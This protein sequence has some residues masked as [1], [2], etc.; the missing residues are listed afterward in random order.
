MVRLNH[1]DGH[2]RPSKD[3][4]PLCYCDVVYKNGSTGRAWRSIGFPEP[5]PLY[6]L[7]EMLASP[8]A[9]VIVTEGEKKAVAA[10]RLFPG[11][12]G[13]APAHGA[14]SPHRTNWSLCRDRHF[15]IWPDHDEPG[16]QFADRVARLLYDAGAASIAIVDVPEDF[17][18]KWDLADPAPEGA[19]LGALLAAAKI[20]TPNI[21]Q[22]PGP[23]DLKGNARRADWLD[24]CQ[25]GRGDMPLNNVTNAALGLRRE[26]T[27]IGCVAYDSFADTV[28]LMRPLPR[29]HEAAQQ[30]DPD[31]FESRHWQ[32]SDT[33][34]VQEWL[35]IL[36]L[37]TLSRANTE[38]AINLVAHENEFDPVKEWIEAQQRDQQS[39]IETWAIDC[40][41]CDDTPYTRAVSRF[42][43]IAAV[44]RIYEPGCKFDYCPILQDEQQGTQKS[45]ALRTLFDP[46]FSDSIP[47]DLN[48]K[49]AK[50]HL[51]G[52]WGLEFAEL[53]SLNRSHIDAVKLFL[54]QQHD[55]YRPSYGRRDQRFPRRCV[56]AGT[57][58][59]TVF[60]TDSSGNRRSWPLRTRNIDIGKLR[61][62]RGALFAEALELYKSHERYWPDRDEEKTLFK[63]E[64]EERFDGDE[65]ESVVVAY[66][67][68]KDRVLVGQ[69]ARDACL[70]TTDKIGRAVQNRII[71]IL[72]RVAWRRGKPDEHGKWW[73]RSADQ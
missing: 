73:T 10:S 71:E 5:R 18:Q 25:V 33:D 65:W 59:R 54:S 14:K 12:A 11:Y 36:G 57:T 45:T 24:E 64:Q 8:D 21:V 68:D 42:Y 4:L 53:H 47:A 1:L 43:I 38:T 40:L 32:D 67:A 46:W 31:E 20:W 6:Q 13:I 62:I 50:Q 28:M 56:F 49:D 2:G 3:Y 26:Q 60:L 61:S 16:R 41:G 19:D 72:E 22:F 30:E 70:V 7:P 55:D 23:A 58:N 17:P 44:A 27:L 66:L 9:P 52:K 35:Q 15:I 37:N 34:Q 39:H 48:A 69:I 29:P 63:P 51:R